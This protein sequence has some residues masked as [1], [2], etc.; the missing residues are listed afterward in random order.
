M[1]DRELFDLPPKEAP[2]GNHHF[3]PAV[4]W[5]SLAGIENGRESN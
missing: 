1:R 4:Q 5:L 3:R 2:H